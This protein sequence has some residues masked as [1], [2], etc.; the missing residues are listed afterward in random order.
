MFLLTLCFG[1]TEFMLITSTQPIRVVLLAVLAVSLLVSCAD[2]AVSPDV[3]AKKLPGDGSVYTYDFKLDSAGAVSSTLIELTV[4]DA[5][6]SRLGK[7]QVWVLRP[8]PEWIL[9]PSL[10]TM[11]GVDEMFSVDSIAT[12]YRLD[13]VLRDMQELPWIRLPL[14]D[15]LPF[16]LAVGKRVGGD[17]LTTVITA[18]FQ[19]KEILPVGS[20]SVECSK[21]LI[22]IK[23]S[24]T[25]CG[26]VDETV[27]MWLWYA[28][29]LY[30]YV[31]QL[32]TTTSRPDVVEQFN[33]VRYT[34]R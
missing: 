22:T 6:S 15:T 1:I 27:S 25:S 18:S 12:Y 26:P 7:G 14:K 9:R 30:T 19:G 11:R 10:D 34:L 8:A 24:G 31:R 33:L 5:N 23:L 20:L 2:E 4:R 21:V 16:D 17:T 3:N 28:P 32:V 13:R 29:T